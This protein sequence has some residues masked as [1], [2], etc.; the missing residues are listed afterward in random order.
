[1]ATQEFYIRNATE[2]EARGPFMVEQLVSLAEAGQVTADTLYYDANAE[3]WLSLGSTPEVRAVI[4]PEKKKLAIRKVQRIASLNKETESQNAINVQDMLAAAEGRTSD[5][6]SRGHSLAMVDRCAKLGL[7]GCTAMLL[8]LACVEI[9]PSIE[10][11]TDFS[12]DKLL[13]APIVALGILDLGMVVLLLLGVAAIYPFVRF[14]AMLGLGFLGLLFWIKGQ[15]EAVAATAVGSIGLYL[16][17]IFLTY[18]S[19]TLAL[20]LG[21]AG[22]GALLYMFVL[23]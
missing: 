2:T 10:V 18:L 7:W 8:I 1:M 4:F 14:R 22:T 9:L 6:R 20:L 23:L 11:V 19:T 15:H 17:T 13:T 5:T 3:R 21:L 12:F 16:S